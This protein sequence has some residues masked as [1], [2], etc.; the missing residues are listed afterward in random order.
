ME[1]RM[2]SA[3]AINSCSPCPRNGNTGDIIQIKTG[4]EKMRLIV[5]ELGRF[6]RGSEE[7]FGPW[8]RCS[9]YA[10]ES[11]PLFC[12]E[13]STSF[14]KFGPSP[15]PAAHLP[16]AISGVDT[17]LLDG[18]SDA[19][20]R[21]HVGG[22][23]V[24]HIVRLGIADDIVEAGCQDVLQLLVDGGFFPEV[25]LSI[26]HPLKVGGSNAASVG[27]YV[28]NDEDFLVSQDF[29]C[30]SGGGS[31]GPF[32]DDAGLDAI[33]V[34]AGDDI[35]GCRGYEDIAL[36]N[37]QLLRIEGLS[38]LESKYAAVTLAIIVERAHVDSV[39]VVEA[40]IVLGDANDLVP[41]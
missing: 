2:K 23:A 3:D 14:V 28:R 37:H 38:T 27:E 12:T 7:D 1:A 41:E 22:D 34:A 17:P 35:L 40:A 19:I 36:G 9:H 32:A 15:T 30:H 10:P 26:L 20:N 11:A 4:T 24:V 6:T 25:A 5:M 33:H 18:G 21:Q 13:G 16:Y 8:W 31:V 29:I 39:A